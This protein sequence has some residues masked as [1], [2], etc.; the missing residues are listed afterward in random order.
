MGKADAAENG[1][2]SEIFGFGFVCK[3]IGYT[4][5]KKGSKSGGNFR[6]T[7][8]CKSINITQN[9]SNIWVSYVVDLLL[10]RSI[11]PILTTYIFIQARTL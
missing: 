3:S 4:V 6:S 8:S 5:G 2:S 11:L 9:L 7:T 1:F 10:F